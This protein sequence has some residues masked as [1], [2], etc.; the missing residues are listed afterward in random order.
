MRADGSLHVRTDKEHQQ[1]KF[2]PRHT[3]PE[4]HIAAQQHFI[5]CLEIGV[6]FETSGV[7]TLKTMALVYAAYLAAEEGRVVHLEELLGG[8]SL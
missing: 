2:S 8:S 6:E 3:N 5:D 4:S 7:E 1:W